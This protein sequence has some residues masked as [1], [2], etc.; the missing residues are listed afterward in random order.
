MVPTAERDLLEAALRYRIRG[1]CVMP[2]PRGQKAP[3]MREWSVGGVLRPEIR[4]AT[5]D[6]ILRWWDGEHKDSNLAL[7]CGPDSGVFVLDIDGPAGEAALQGL[8]I[9][10]GPQAKTSR[11]RHLFFE[12]PQGV[13]IP[14]C[15]GLRGKLDLR[16]RGSYVLLPPSLHPDGVYYRWLDDSEALEPPPAPAWLLEWIAAAAVKDVPQV[17]GGKRSLAPPTK[18]E[19]IPEGK[20]NYMLSQ[21]AGRLRW[22]GLDGDAIERELL[23]VNQRQCSPPLPDFEV[24]AI[25]R[26]ISRYQKGAIV[27]GSQGDALSPVDLEIFLAEQENLDEA[28]VE[29]V[30]AEVTMQESLP[31]LGY[32]LNDTGNSKHLFDACSSDFLFCG[33]WFFWTGQCWE[34]DYALRALERTHLVSEMLLRQAEKLDE[35]NAEV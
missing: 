32:P 31:P 14:P 16:G 11:G 23:V 17:V 22:A 33:S 13:T 3:P 4:S 12:Y 29:A 34:R 30:S 21:I 28:Y 9:P 1:W 19:A 25:A 5:E 20:R 7:C 27:M 10:A 18:N 6:T 24:S 15:V 26:S 2:L 8:E 35:S